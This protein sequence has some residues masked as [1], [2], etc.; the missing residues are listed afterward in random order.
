M[1]R[2]NYQR[3]PGYAD[4]VATVALFAA[5]GGAATAAE[6][7][8]NGGTRTVTSLTTHMTERLVGAK[9]QPAFGTGW[10]N[11]GAPFQVA[12]FYKDQGGVV[13][14]RGDVLGPPG[15][16]REWTVFTLPTGYRPEAA[17]IF[18][19]TLGPGGTAALYVYPDGS[20]RCAP[21]ASSA[22]VSLSG[23]SFR[24]GI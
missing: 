11:T 6:I 2:P 10:S 4:I 17:E 3:R 12:G 13:H 8:G 16:R 9:H 5:L 23:I 21:L 14:L 7:P 24:A 15:V 20:V 18:A 19:A 22:D 1:K